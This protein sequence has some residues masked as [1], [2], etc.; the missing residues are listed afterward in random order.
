MLLEKHLASLAAGRGRGW[1]RLTC[2]SVALT[3]CH[4]AVVEPSQ[5]QR[6]RQRQKLGLG[7]VKTTVLVWFR[8]SIYVVV[9]FYEAELFDRVYKTNYNSLILWEAEQDQDRCEKKNSDGKL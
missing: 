7:V 2:Q 1:C 8:N 6:V 5:Q 3:Y 9:F 4:A